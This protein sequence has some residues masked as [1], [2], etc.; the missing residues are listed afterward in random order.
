VVALHGYHY[1]DEVMETARVDCVR[2]LQSAPP[3]K[4]PIADIDRLYDIARDLRASDRSSTK[5]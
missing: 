5:A 4:L 2:I 3:G 1:A